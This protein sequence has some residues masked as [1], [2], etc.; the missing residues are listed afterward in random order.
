[1]KPESMLILVAHGSRDPLWRGSIHNLAEAVGALMPNEE[2]RVAFM[3]FDG[4]TLADVVEEAA[5]L[6]RT[7]LRLLPLF[8]ASAG[9]VDKDIKPL[10]RELA[11][12]H[13]A[14]ELE[15]LTTVGESGPFPALILEIANSQKG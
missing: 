12:T 4:P 3:Q 5:G 10:V 2:V 7:H 11:Q 15:L 1:M 14:L 6:G 9:H 13:P 8:M